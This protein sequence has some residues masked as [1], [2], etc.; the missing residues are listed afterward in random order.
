RDGTGGVAVGKVAAGQQVSFPVI[1][2]Q[3]PSEAKAVAL[4]ITTTT[5]DGPGYATVWPHGQAMP[6]TSSV[7]V[8]AVGETAANAAIVPVGQDGMLDLSTFEGADLVADLT[9]YWVPAGSTVDGRFHSVDT[10]TRL[11]DTRDGTGGKPGGAFAA[12]E[13]FDVQVTG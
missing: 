10:P 13:Q 8:S 4:N 3:V 6:A 9:G 1:G 12:G 11:L 5:V 7:N 2:G